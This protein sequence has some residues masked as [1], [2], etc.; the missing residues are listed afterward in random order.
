[1]RKWVNKMVKKQLMCRPFALAAI[2]LLVLSMA[3][4]TSSVGQENEEAPAEVEILAIAGPLSYRPNPVITGADTIV[5]T[6]LDI[7]LPHVPVLSQLSVS[8]D[9]ADCFKPVDPNAQ[10]ARISPGQSIELDLSAC[11]DDILLE[12]ECQQHPGLMRGGLI[13][14]L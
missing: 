9:H 14:R 3:G 10:N 4:L 7:I 12:F 8:E 1:M 13:I 2:A 6:N 5:F 11:P